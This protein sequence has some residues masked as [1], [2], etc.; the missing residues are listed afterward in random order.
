MPSA[1]LGFIAGNDPLVTFTLYSAPG[2]VANLTG[3]T[4]DLYLKSGPNVSDTDPT[5]LTY[6]STQLNSP[7]VITNATGGVVTMQFHASD[8]VGHEWYHLD[9]VTNGLRLTYAYGS[10]SATIV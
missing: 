10:L 2:T 4:L 3:A 5:T 8:L 6:T 1:P 9:V 7:L